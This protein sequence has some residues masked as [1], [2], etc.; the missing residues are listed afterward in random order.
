MS[1]RVTE[2]TSAAVA[3]AGKRSGDRTNERGTAALRANELP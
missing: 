1:A 2:R 3:G